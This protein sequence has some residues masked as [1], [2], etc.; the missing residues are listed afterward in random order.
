MSRTLSK[1][2]KRIL[3]FIFFVYNFLFLFIMLIIIYAYYCSF[4]GTTLIIAA[5]FA[6]C[7][8]K[9]SGL[10]TEWSTRAAGQHV[11]YVSSVI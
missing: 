8:Y 7:L 4:L 5:K 2:K 1:M 10:A 9:L 3:I 11:G 6:P